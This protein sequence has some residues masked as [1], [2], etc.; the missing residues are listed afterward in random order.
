[1]VCSLQP[2]YS[3]KSKLYIEQIPNTLTGSLWKKCLTVPVLVKADQIINNT[4][5]K[6]KLDSLTLLLAVFKY[7]IYYNIITEFMKFNF[8]FGCRTKIFNGP[9]WPP[10]ITI[11]GGATV[12]KR[13][14]V[15][16]LLSKVT[17]TCCK[18]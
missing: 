10:L 6:I 5:C 13:T 18:I 16:F 9:T 8:W 2:I 14:N 3:F 17:Y 1:M 11:F 12:C 4:N 7:L 15:L